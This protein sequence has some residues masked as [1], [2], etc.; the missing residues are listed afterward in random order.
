M[1]CEKKLA[2]TRPSSQTKTKLPPFILCETAVTAYQ[3][4]KEMSNTR[5]GY[6]SNGFYAQLQV[7]PPEPV[8]YTS[9]VLESTPRTHFAPQSVVEQQEELRLL[10]S[11]QEHSSSQVQD[12]ASRL[13]VMEKHLMDISNSLAPISAPAGRLRQKVPAS[14]SVSACCLYQCVNTTNVSGTT[15]LISIHVQRKVKELHSVLDNQFHPEE[16]YAPLYY[17]TLH[18]FT[19]H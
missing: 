1:P 7:T 9:R 4:P 15:I 6:C 12:I 16:G 5:T 18:T 13:T 8:P 10:R 3:L 2:A 19:M 17:C 11:Q 14:L